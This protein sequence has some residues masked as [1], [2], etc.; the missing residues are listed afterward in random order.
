MKP[1]DVWIKSCIKK[2]AYTHD[3]ADSMIVKIKKKRNVELRKYYCP[4]CSHWHL[5]SK[6][7]IE[8]K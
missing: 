8:N 4:H 1:I 7:I 6:L 5:T 3:Q 2:K